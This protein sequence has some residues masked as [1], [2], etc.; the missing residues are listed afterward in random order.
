MDEVRWSLGQGQHEWPILL[1]HPLSHLSLPTLWMEKGIPQEACWF[2]PDLFCTL[3]WHTGTFWS[4]LC[5][6]EAER[7]GMP[8]HLL[9]SLHCPSTLLAF[10]QAAILSLLRVQISKLI[11]DFHC[12]S[13]FKVLTL[14]K[15]PEDNC[16]TLHWPKC[17]FCPYQ[18]SSCSTSV[19][20][21]LKSSHCI[22]EKLFFVII[23]LSVPCG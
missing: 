2:F 1:I 17:S 20:K 13:F 5:H 21:D 12:P 7:L 14:K 16:R 22:T 8:H 23:H 4:I 19:K 6:T 15:R 11:Q 3:L 10:R 9:P 18:C